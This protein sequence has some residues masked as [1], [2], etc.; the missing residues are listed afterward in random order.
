MA[1]NN[2]S[3]STVSN[4]RFGATELRDIWF[5]VSS[6]TLPTISLAPPEMNTRAGANI[7]IAPDTAVYTDLS[8][9]IIIDKEWEVFDVIYSY[10]LQGLDVEQGTF[11]HN[12][13]FELWLEVVDGEGNRMKKFNFHSCRL[14]EFTGLESLP[15]TDADDHQTL[16]LIFNV[17]YYTVDG[18]E[19]KFDNNS[20]TK[21]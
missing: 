4:M 6:I 9:E 2:N 1:I 10:F 17:M 13:N 15:N 14:S 20:L 19:H 12:K 21:F 11:T 16:S 18:L 8:L 7:H 3:F 5:N